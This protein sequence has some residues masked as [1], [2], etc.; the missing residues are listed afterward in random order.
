MYVMYEKLV[1]A[2][3][4]QAVKDYADLRN[5]GLSKSKNKV[6]LGDGYSI[7]EIERFLV[8]PWGASLLQG[9]N[10]RVLFARL[11]NLFYYRRIARRKVISQLR[12]TTHGMGSPIPI[13][14]KYNFSTVV[15]ITVLFVCS[16]FN[17]AE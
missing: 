17:D 11:D 14:T 13:I 1:C 16:K 15:I 3:F 5:R 4:S 2:I 9:I 6:S 7:R 12:F 10:S 8:S